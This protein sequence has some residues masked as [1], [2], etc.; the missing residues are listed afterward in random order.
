MKVEEY[1]ALTRERN[2]DPRNMK[3]LQMGKD[4]SSVLN[5]IL[6]HLQL[7]TIS[8]MMQIK[9]QHIQGNISGERPTG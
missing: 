4:K 9:T 8:R 6:L 7:Q 2:N 3:G 5:K 1:S